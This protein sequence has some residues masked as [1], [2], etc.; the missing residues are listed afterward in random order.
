MSKLV[1]KLQILSRTANYGIFFWSV[2]SY[3]KNSF[4]SFTQHYVFSIIIRRTEISFVPWIYSFLCSLS[5]A[6]L[7]TMNF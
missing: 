6:S 1:L 7:Q 3:L 2:M 4:F 5:L